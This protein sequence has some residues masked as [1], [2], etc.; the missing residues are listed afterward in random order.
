MTL[1]LHLSLDPLYRWVATMD[2]EKRYLQKKE[3]TKDVVGAG[4]WNIYVNP[5]L[6]GCCY[7]YVRPLCKHTRG[8][9]I[10]IKLIDMWD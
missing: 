7:P 8:C 4:F 10:H 5:Q 3:K 6:G 2:F 1:A 9:A